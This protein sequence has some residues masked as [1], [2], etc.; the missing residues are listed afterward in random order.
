MRWAAA[1]ALIPWGEEADWQVL[2]V[3]NT[4]MCVQQLGTR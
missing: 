4:S 1:E 2:E 3:V